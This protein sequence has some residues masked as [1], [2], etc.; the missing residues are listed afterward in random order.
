MAAISVCLL[1]HEISHGIVAARY[2][3]VPRKLVFSLYLMVS[4]VAYLKIPGMYTLTP[5]KRI[6]IW[7]AGMYTNF[8]LASIFLLA[9]FFTNFIGNEVFYAIGLTNLICIVMS[10]SPFMPTDGYFIM[11]TLLKSP[12]LRKNITSGTYKFIDK[13]NLLK[14]VYLILTILIMFTLFITQI[15][16]IIKSIIDTYDESLSIM[17]FII[18]IKMFIIIF[19]IVIVKRIIKH[20]NRKV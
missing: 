10:I 4:P 2:G 19:I 15:I 11:S 9:Y 1:F 18:K 12:N 5:K 14:S 7:L 3:L 13:N 8:C 16:F 17:E 6:H 20:I